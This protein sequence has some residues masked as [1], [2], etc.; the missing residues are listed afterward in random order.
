MYSRPRVT[1][2]PLPSK[3]VVEESGIGKGSVSEVDE[4]LVTSFEVP[5]FEVVSPVEV[6]LPLAKGKE[7]E[8]RAKRERTVPK[9][10]VLNFSMPGY[11]P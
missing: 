3:G 1:M 7:Q 4:L 5:V 10:R 8:L 2:S 6:S 9:V 11:L